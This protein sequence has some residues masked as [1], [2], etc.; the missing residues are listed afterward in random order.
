MAVAVRA[1]GVYVG[2]KFTSAGGQI[3]TNISRW[4]RDASQWSSLGSGTSNGV[5]DLVQ[6]ITVIGSDLY[7]GGQFTTSGGIST[8]HISRW[9]TSGSQWHPLGSGT[10]NGVNG[11]VLAMTVSGGLYVGG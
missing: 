6:A 2:G 8:N 3:A 7:V 5:N 11:S 9:D 10:S 4:N 1:G